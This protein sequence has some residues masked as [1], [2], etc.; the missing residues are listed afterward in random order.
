M[1]EE[2]DK[3]REGRKLVI[4]DHRP[5]AGSASVWTNIAYLKLWHFKDD[6]LHHISL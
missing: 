2:K 4:S 3:E 5:L 6:S 1:K